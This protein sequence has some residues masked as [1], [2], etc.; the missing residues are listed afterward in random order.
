LTIIAIKQLS[1][2]KY[3]LS[4]NVKLTKAVGNAAIE[5]DD[6]DYEH[7][8]LEGWRYEP[9]KAISDVMESL[10]GA[11]LVDSG[12]DFEGIRVIIE[13]IMMPILEVLR[14]DLPRD[15]TSELLLSLAKQ[16]CQRAKFQ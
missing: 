16:G 1:L 3:L 7:V 14:P 2:H 9:P 11:M 15:P 5:F 13:R 10:C 6:F 4:N 8:V 12:Y